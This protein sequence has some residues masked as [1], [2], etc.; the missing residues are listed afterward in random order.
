MSRKPIRQATDKVIHIR[1]DENVHH[2]LKMEAAS[3]RI[4]IQEIVE[5]MLKRKFTHK[6]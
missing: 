4:T 2:K 3:S 5:G 1:V 6:K